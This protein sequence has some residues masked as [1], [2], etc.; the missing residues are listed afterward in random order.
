M[1]H[2]LILK[3]ITNDLIELIPKYLHSYD[4]KGF[5]VIKHRDSLELHCEVL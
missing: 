5:K 4:I 3:G 2:F 1:K